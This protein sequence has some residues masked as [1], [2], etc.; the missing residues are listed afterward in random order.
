MEQHNRF[1]YGWED[2]DS[3]QEQQAAPLTTSSLPGEPC[4]GTHQEIEAHPVVSSQ[5][6]EAMQ[7]TTDDLPLCLNRLDHSYNDSA[8]R[9]PVFNTVRRIDRTPHLHLQTPFQMKTL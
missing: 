6:S 8:F 3:E 7:A 9:T 4:A 1:H 5:Q 2:S